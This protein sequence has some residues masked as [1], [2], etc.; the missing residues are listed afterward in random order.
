MHIPRAWVTASGDGKLA[1][2]RTAPVT[3]W[4][5]GDDE[6]AARSTALQRLKRVLERLGRGE[7]FPDS[8][9]YLS[10]PLR[11]E[12]LETVAGP[13]DAPLA[14]LTRNRYGAQVLNAA[15]LLFLDI[16][17]PPPSLM[18]RLRALFGAPGAQ[19]RALARLRQ[20]LQQ[21]GRATFRLYRTAAG[22]RAIAVDREFDPAGDDTRALMQATGTDPAFARLCVAQKSFRARLTPK[23]WR[24]RLR[25]P[26]GQHP[27][28]GSGATAFA[29]WLREYEKASGAFATC[30][31]LETVGTGSARGDARAL[32]DLHDRLTRSAT[33]LPLA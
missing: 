23:P 31:Y 1:D 25:T 8:Y 13:A 29:A 30:R 16:D 24:C 9:A 22:L 32:I 21:H 15:R 20:A 7:P 19:A 4:G 11:E 6:T 27:R 17:F 10:R 18:D 26:P 5:W 3:V 28:D 2:G 33:A 12:I 14:L